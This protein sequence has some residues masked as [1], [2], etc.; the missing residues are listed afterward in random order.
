MA[1]PTH[2]A[3]PSSDRQLP[4]R[5]GRHGGALQKAEADIDGADLTAKA[6]AFLKLCCDQEITIATAESC[7]DGLIAALLTGIEGVSHA[8]DRAFIV[9]TEAAKTEVLGVPAEL[10]ESR[11][12]VSS[13]VAIAMA[14]GAIERPDAKV[15]IAMTG[16]AGPTS[17]STEGLVHLAAARRGGAIR[18][19]CLE[20]GSIGR[21]S[22]RDHAAI[23]AM[24]VMIETL[25][26]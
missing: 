8:F 4:A 13:E 23:A 11:T 19:R 21:D 17:E 18:Q 20:L 1:G 15:A 3:L 25:D 14:R 7:T 5:D 16:Y 26:E 6:D 10:I 24:D 12:A 2:Q 9:Y 22:I